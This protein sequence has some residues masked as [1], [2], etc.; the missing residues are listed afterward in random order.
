MNFCDIHTHLLYGVDDGAEN[1]EQMK[2]ILDEAYSDGTRTICATPHFHPG[3]FGENTA[4]VNVAFEKLKAYAAR[5]PDLKLCLGNELRYSLSCGEWLQSGACRT[6]NGTQYV[7][8]DFLEYDD[9]D[10]IVEATLK[11]F[12]SGYTPILAHAERYESF[13]RDMREIEYL[14]SCGA[15]IQVDAGSPFGGW[16]RGS[17][18]RSRRII[19]A[20][21]ADIVASDAHNTMSRPPI[22]SGCYEYVRDKCGREYADSLFIQ[23]PQLILADLEIRKDDEL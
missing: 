18:I 17:K 22:L 12:N 11:V 3:F 4:A 2:K 13:S 5:Y 16:G 23:N 1:E 20:Q 19:E 21:L 8:V 15:I 6:I 10:F 7:L 9:A 14:R